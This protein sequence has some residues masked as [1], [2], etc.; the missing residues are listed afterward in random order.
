MFTESQ[1]SDEDID[2][3]LEERKARLRNLSM[4]IRTPEGLSELENEPAYKRRNMPLADIPSS[5]ES[6]IS[7]YTLSDNGD[8]KIEI[9]SNNSFLHD[10]VD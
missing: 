3:K 8:K 1:I 5:S 7:R 10:N 2:R 4:K 9:R 6:E